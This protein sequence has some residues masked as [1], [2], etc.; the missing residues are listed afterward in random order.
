LTVSAIG[1]DG[2]P[3]RGTPTF[4]SSDPNAVAVAA[5]G[6]LT[7]KHLNLAPVTLT[8]TEAGKSATLQVTTFGL[9]AAGGT[10]PTQLDREVEVNSFFAATFRDANGNIAPTGTEAMIQGPADFNGGA[11]YTIRL[12][13][14][15]SYI[16]GAPKFV[17]GQYTATATVGGQTFVRTFKMD[18]STTLAIPKSIQLSATRTTYTATGTFPAGAVLADAL[19]YSTESAAFEFTNDITQLPST[20]SWQT[21]LAAGNYGVSITAYSFDF[22]IKKSLPDQINVA[23][24]YGSAITVN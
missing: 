21:P 18:G 8:V 16:V 10:D 23:T 15:F 9:D 12:K 24:Y 4:T 2:Q 1:S 20:A 11:P 19:L 13:K 5:D 6:S 14:N 3:Y 17:A 22:D 7:V